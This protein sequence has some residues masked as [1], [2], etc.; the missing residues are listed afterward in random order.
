MAGFYRRTSGVCC[1]VV[2]DGETALSIATEKG[3]EAVVVVL[4]KVSARLP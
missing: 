2:Q 1:D 4:L 3:L